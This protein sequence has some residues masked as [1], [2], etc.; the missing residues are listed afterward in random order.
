MGKPL[1]AP[2]DRGV[3][4]APPLSNPCSFFCALLC[5]LGF[6]LGLMGFERPAEDKTLGS[7]GWVSTAQNALKQIK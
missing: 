3:S 4:I 6:R 2:F 5:T 7:K 1:E